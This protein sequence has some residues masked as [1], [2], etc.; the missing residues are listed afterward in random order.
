MTR[1]LSYPDALSR[2]LVEVRPI[3]ETESVRL[4][5][6]PCR[7]LAEAVESD[8]DLPPFDRAQMDGYA[9][10]AEEVGRIDSWPVV[11]TI[12][13]G[14]PGDAII[15]PGACAA[16]ATGAPL[17][18][19][20]DT[21]I[22][23]ELSDRAN[24]VR[25]TIKS[26]EKGHAVHRRGADTRASQLI[27]AP[28]TV[29]RPHHLGIA[30]S[31]GCI[32]LRVIRRPRVAILTSGDEIVPVDAAPETHQVRNS[33]AIMLSQLLIRTG[34]EVIAQ[35]HLPDD[36]DQTVAAVQES[37]LD[38]DLLLTVGGISA[39]DRDHFAAAF[40]TNGVRSTLHGAAIQ[41]GG[42]IYVGFAPITTVVVGLPG[43]PVSVLA[44]TCL[45]V[46]PILRAMCGL[47]PTLPWRGATLAEP[48][49][50]NAKRQAFRPAIL[51]EDGTALVPTWSGS[52]DLVHTAPTHGLLEL[53]VQDVPVAPGT[54]LRFLPWP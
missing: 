18:P 13:A 47:D 48:V 1:T 45:F 41:P 16:I 24:P 50:P 42:P 2:A 39:G 28:G 9:L 52:G 54:T 29:V 53:P 32:S 12:P 23:H 22:Q 30:A 51:R 43:N 17:P 27:L 11:A 14:A 26:I 10:R 15:P 38:S 20:T 44:C 3:V 49:M 5:E 7:V 34:V 40:E 31:V 37:L 4:E 6:S 21:V 25:F 46:W 19:G 8:R 35:T 33:N 36:L